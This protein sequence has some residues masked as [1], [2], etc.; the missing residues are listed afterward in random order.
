MDTNRLVAIALLATTTLISAGSSVAA[1]TDSPNPPGAGWRHP[2]MGAG[3]YM[4]R[5]AAWRG[6][7]ARGMEGRG[8]EGCPMGPMGFAAL[9]PGNEKIAMQMHGDELACNNHNNAW[10]MLPAM[11]CVITPPASTLPDLKYH[12]G[13]QVG[14]TQR[15]N[16]VSHGLMHLGKRQLPVE[17]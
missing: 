12:Q 14:H 1:D 10:C 4:D 11:H 2:M 5:Q 15:R 3:P 17:L 6:M 13:G 8:M 7:E 16:H 9:P